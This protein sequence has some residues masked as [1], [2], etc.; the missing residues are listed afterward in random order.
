[1]AEPAL[2]RARDNIKRLGIANVIVVDA[3]VQPLGSG[4]PDGGKF[5]FVM[6]YD[7]LHDLAEPEKMMQEVRDVLHPDGVWVVVDIASEGDAQAN[8]KKHPGAAAYY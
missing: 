6:C 1:V 7:V 2:E 3:K 8:I 5:D 4:P